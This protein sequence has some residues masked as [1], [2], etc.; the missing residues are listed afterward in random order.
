MLLRSQKLRILPIFSPSYLPLGAYW[1]RGSHLSIN[2]V[3]TGSGKIRNGLSPCFWNYCLDLKLL[4]AHFIWNLTWN[5]FNIQKRKRDKKTKFWN[6]ELP[7]C[8]IPVQRILF[9]SGNILQCVSLFIFAL[10]AWPNI[11]PSER[12]RN[13]KVNQ[14]IGSSGFLYV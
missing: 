13:V 3:F 5:L 11:P 9:F 6:F 8:L 14:E 10:S 1:T 12:K 4:F 2:V 7:Y